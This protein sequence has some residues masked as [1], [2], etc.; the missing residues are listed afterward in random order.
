MADSEGVYSRITLMDIPGHA[1]VAIN[2][3][4]NSLASSYKTPVPLQ[5][6]SADTWE[7]VTDRLK[8]LL[9]VLSSHCEAPSIR[10]EI[11]VITV[12]IWMTSIISSYIVPMLQNFGTIGLIW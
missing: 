5:L 8:I 7:E 4:A 6:D 2:E 12:T 1:D 3:T 10:E 9:K 11:V